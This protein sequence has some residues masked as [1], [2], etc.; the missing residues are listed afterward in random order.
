MR[1]NKAV[2]LYDLTGNMAEPWRKAGYTCY[3]VDMQHPDGVSVDPQRPGLIKVG[4]KLE[5]D[6]NTLKALVAVVGNGDVA[7]VAGFPPCDDMA[8]SGARWFEAKLKANPE[9]QNQAAA[10]ARFVEV[11]G[12]RWQCPW[13]AENPVSILSTMWRKPDF[14]FDPCD[15][16]M[17]LP[18]DDVH[19][20]HPDIIPR[21]DRYRKKTLIWCGNGF[22]QPQKLPYAPLKEANP[23]WAKLGGKSL[24]TKNIRSATP[25]G[26]ALAVF[27][28]N[29]DDKE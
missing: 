27:E 9:C 3:I 22:I 8:V 13:M 7:F 11:M 1:R 23:G 21:R 25:R 2:F 10:R 18:V 19:P 14:S 15:Y 17:Y 26:F 28:A 29:R 24:R 20:E 6:F 16:A 12:N 5:D 4:M